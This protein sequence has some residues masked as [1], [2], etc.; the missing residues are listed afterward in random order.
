MA[1]RHSDEAVGGISQIHSTFVALFV[2]P[3]NGVQGRA[4]LCGEPGTGLWPQ[5]HPDPDKLLCKLR[6]F[7]PSLNTYRSC[8][9]VCMLFSQR[10]SRES[11]TAAYP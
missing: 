6:F 10:I 4:G 3:S 2:D 11:T 9:V 5:A 7:A 1:C 8:P